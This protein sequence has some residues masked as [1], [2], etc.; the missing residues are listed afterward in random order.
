[1]PVIEAFKLAE[2]ID[3]RDDSTKWCFNMIIACRHHIWRI[4]KG[5]FPDDSKESALL[6]SYV[7]TESPYDLAQPAKVNAIIEK[8]EEVF[9]RK[10]RDPQNL[11]G[12]VNVVNT[13]LQTMKNSVGDFV[14]QLV[15]KDLC[16]SMS[17]MQVLIL[18]KGLQKKSDDM[19]D[20]RD[21]AMS[22]LK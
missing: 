12:A 9:A 21:G 19:C 18:H 11:E 13:I 6:Q 20:L 7:T 15:L 5:E 14:L 10:Q 22:L 17:K 3:Q 2:C 4:M 8:R 16:K 1:M